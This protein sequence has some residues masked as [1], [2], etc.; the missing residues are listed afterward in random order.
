MIKKPFE[1][2][3]EHLKILSKIESQRVVKGAQPPSVKLIIMIVVAMFFIEIFLMPD[4]FE[5][6]MLLPVI[7][8]WGFVYSYKNS[9]AREAGK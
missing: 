1:E 2:T 8:V 4:W 5:S 6:W 9:P 7:L 3:I